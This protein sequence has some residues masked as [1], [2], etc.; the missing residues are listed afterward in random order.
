M[1]V[2][3]LHDTI[4]TSNTAPGAHLEGNVVTCVVATCNACPNNMQNLPELNEAALA[5][6]PDQ[7]L[8]VQIGLCDGCPLAAE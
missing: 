6:P 5:L 7:Y 2:W 4:R 8:S 1:K 3:P